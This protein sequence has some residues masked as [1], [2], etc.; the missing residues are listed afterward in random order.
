MQNKNLYLLLFLSFLIS[1]TGC[2]KQT[3]PQNTTV[4]SPSGNILV[5]FQLDKNGAP[6]YLVNYKDKAVIDTSSLGFEFKDQA[7]MANGFKLIGAANTSFAETW[8][9]PWGEQR[10]VNNN[11]NELIVRLQE[12]NAPKR[13]LNIYFR[14][15]DDGIGFRYEFPQQ[16]GVDSLIIMDE[17]TQFKLTADHTVWW[18]P[19]DWDSY[20][21]PYYTTRF[22]AIDA[23]KMNGSA[24]VNTSCIPENA[25]N[26]PVTMRTDNGLYL[27]FHE[28]DLLDY[29][30]I[31]LK[32]NPVSLS[33][34]SALVGSE[35]LGYKV[36]RALPFKTPWRTIQI[37]ESAKDLITSR[38]ILNLNEP[39][40]IGDVS[41]VKPQKYVGVWW[42][43]HIDKAT[44]DMASGRHGATTANAKRYID[45]AAANNIGGVLVEGWNTGWEHW[46]GF[47]DREG[48]FDF[49]TPYPDYDLP[50][51]VRYAKEKGVDI[52][53]HHE[54]SSAP[55]TYEQQLEKAYTLMQ[56]LGIHAVK[57]GYVGKIIPNGEHHHSQW[58]VRHYQKVYETA[59]KYQIAVDVHEP[60]MDTGTRR[61]YPNAISREGLRGQEYN[62]WSADGG[63]LPE[64]ISIVAFTRMLAGPIDFT[65]GVF[66]IAIASKPN[67]QVNT[68]LAQQLA[69]YVVIYSPIQMACDLPENYEGQPAFQFIRD[70]GVDWEQT[71]VLNGEVGDFV[72]IAREE[73]GTGNWFI[74]S[75]TDENKRDIEVIFNFLP[76]GVNYQAKIYQDGPRAHYR[77]NPRDIKIEEMIVTNET[78]KIFTLAP[79]GGLAISLKTVK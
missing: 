48:V 63:N 29:A 46:V 64:H 1:I 4:T 67:N 75:V 56:S 7:P 12:I 43:M 24:L 59:A 42:E 30:G 19:G 3:T 25:V 9:M 13:K 16:K 57:T 51:V 33:M 41:W 54:T 74:G 70:V 36:K 26:T 6:V 22:S 15:H 18:C 50:E 53:M 38:L 52:I 44:W 60:I 68:T 47:E 27:S 34:T 71:V 39:N 35:R 28:A 76:A 49:V 79:G 72:T 62:A 10:V 14:A 31:T 61:T 23:Q 21:H 78:V 2:S 58:M 8:E 69:L 17:N 55:R 40:K 20:E 37:S 77:D 65:P 66:D 11:Y 32:I 45:F 5:A 73:R